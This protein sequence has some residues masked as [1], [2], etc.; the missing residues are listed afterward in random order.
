MSGV[1]PQAPGTWPGARRRPGAGFWIVA[2]TFLVTMAFSAVPAPLY[3]L[4]QRRDG[5]GPLMVTVIFAAYAVGVVAT[6]FLAGH[7]SDWLGRRRILAIAVA[8]NIASGILFLAWPSVPGLIVARLISGAS[9]GMLTATAT[10]HLTE[11]H[12]SARPAAS[13]ARAD[14][15]ATA[16]NLGGLGLGPLVSGLLAQYAADALQVP[17]LVA[18]ALM[19]LGVATLAAAPE[20]APRPA[21]RPAY[22]PQRVSVPHAHRSLYFAAGIAGAAEFAVFGLFTSLAP[23]FIAG[24]L[25][26]RSHAL[27]GFATFV[28]F[29]MAALAQIGASRAPLRR[30][31][32]IGLGV[33]VAGLVLVTAAVWLASLPLLLAGGAIAGAGAGAAFKGCVSTVIT[34]AP[35][36]ARG[37]ALAGLFLAGYV[38]LAIP[39]MGLGVAVQLL[40]A[41]TALVG[42]AAVLIGV[43]ALVSRRLVRPVPALP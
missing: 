29:G 18:E 40:S 10:A 25:G 21:V 14:I 41:R 26:D 4:Y 34:I 13:R 24:T 19:L 39:V 36:G 38:G 15:V 32:G 33:L 22:R 1:Q 12:A 42:F 23:G 28:V 37:E 17:Y 20:T 3:V 43:V 30:Q 8:V 5:F 2:Y 16:A 7:V 27:A 9:V 31:L 35:A 6:L 11:L